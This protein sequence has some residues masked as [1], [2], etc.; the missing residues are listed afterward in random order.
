MAGLIDRG[1]LHRVTLRFLDSEVEDTYQREEGAAG[2]NGFRLI[3]GA[4]VLLWSVAAV[5]I[6]MG[7]SLP[8]TVTVPVGGSMALVGLACYSLSR[9][10][11]TLNRQHVLASALTSANGLVILI[12]A[13]VGD[14]VKG[15]AVG[16]LM[17]LFAYGFL[18]RTRF[19][20][21]A[22]RTV[23]ISAGLAVTVAVYDGPGSL[24][25]DIFLFVTAALG[26]LL[27]LRLLERDRRRVWHQRLVIAEQTAAIEEE[28]AESERLLLNILPASVS[29]RL[30]GGEFPI[31]DDFP[32]V[33]V[34]FA[35][36]VGFTSLAA[37]LSAGEVITMLTALYTCFDDLVTTRGLEKI[38]TIGTHTWQW[39]DFPSPSTGTPSGSS[40]W[41]RR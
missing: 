27:A 9:W 26:T 11:T 39:V 37:T 32:S 5:L 36:I 13:T 18:A 28:R 17:L 2:L 20:H 16:G 14:V 40:T 6:P 35:D 15:Y 7:T 24:I 3:A 22:V 41:R 12:L 33:S 23:V 8:A 29:Y 1:S 38:K 4:T 19:V 10:A 31:A 21:A 25:I 30:K 34:V